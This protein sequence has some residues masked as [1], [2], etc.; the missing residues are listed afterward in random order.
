MPVQNSFNTVTDLQK[1]LKRSNQLIYVSVIFLGFA[2][3]MAYRGYID[4][5]N[6]PPT[7]LPLGLMLLGFSGLLVSIMLGKGDGR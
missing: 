3:G 7:L 2:S 5:A 1:S 6:T 4:A